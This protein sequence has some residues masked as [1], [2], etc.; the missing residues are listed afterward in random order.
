[1]L[2]REVEWLIINWGFIL[3]VLILINMC[4]QTWIIITVE[5]IVSFFWN[6]CCSPRDLL[7]YCHLSL[8]QNLSYLGSV[9]NS[10][11]GFPGW[12]GGFFWLP[13][14]VIL[15]RLQVKQ[16]Y[17]FCLVGWCSMYISWILIHFR[18]LKSPI[19]HM[20]ITRALPKFGGKGCSEFTVYFGWVLGST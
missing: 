5:V 16:W 6:F 7:N 11:G 13:T 1:M 2:W 3:A 4:Q 20:E 14:C 8:Q 17:M 12:P 19:W 18:I 10:G 9:V 15:V